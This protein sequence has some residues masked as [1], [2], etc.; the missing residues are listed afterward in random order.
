MKAHCTTISV[1]VCP[2]G[3]R[4]YLSHLPTLFSSPSWSLIQGLVC[5]VQGLCHWDASPKSFSLALNYVALLQHRYFCLH[6]PWTGLVHKRHSFS[7]FLSCKTHFSLLQSCP[8]T[9]QPLLKVWTLYFN[10]IIAE[11]CTIV[12]WSILL[13][14]R[15]RSSLVTERSADGRNS[16]MKT[17]STT[18]ELTATYRP[19]AS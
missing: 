15:T 14:W 4:I 1:S 11:Q 8:P 18:A 9:P 17:Y 13:L 3:S 19:S 5:A 2:V 10:T 7:S 16:D 6:I 12:G